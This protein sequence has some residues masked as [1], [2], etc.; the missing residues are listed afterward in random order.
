MTA[1]SANVIRTPQEW[2][3][4]LGGDVM[5]NGRTIRFPRPGGKS[6][7]RSCT[8]TVGS[9]FPD[10]VSVADGRDGPNRISW[11]DLKDYCFEQAGSPSFT[12]RRAHQGHRPAGRRHR[13][14]SGA[15]ASG[16]RREEGRGSPPTLFR[17]LDAEEALATKAPDLSWHVHEWIPGNNVFM[18]AGHGGE[19]KSILGLQLCHQTRCGMPFFGRAVRAGAAVFYS[20]EES[21]HELAYRLQ[22]IATSVVF[23]GVPENPLKLIS[24]ADR[25]ALLAIASGRLEELVHDLEAVLLVID[26]RADVF[27]GDEIDRAEVRSFIALLRG[28]AIR[29]QCAVVLLEHP[30]V[31]GMNEGRGF[32]GSTAWHNSV[33]GLAT[34]TTPKE[35]KG[36]EIDPCLRVLEFKKVQNAARGA[37]IFMR[38][39][40]GA[41]HG[42]KG[43]VSADEM[44]LEQ[45][46]KAMKILLELVQK[47]NDR[48][49]RL[50]DKPSPSYAAT[51]LE[52]E[53][54]A[55]GVTKKQLIWALREGL[56]QN[57]LRM[58]S[59][60]YDGKDRGRLVVNQ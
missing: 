59:E 27:G 4:I 53:A 19:G 12:D 36:Q 15:A 6:K 41:F 11:Q 49:Q 37:K 10:G 52:H 39:D 8:L 34:L 21:E 38:F 17:V 47:A 56:A 44:S 32:S 54:K 24:M 18:L 1:A 28:I 13:P 51:M 31:A 58:N 2:A 16:P 57:K 23:K 5:P 22:R 40:N 45:K 48:G 26:A 33:R 3:R 9:Q 25:S 55:L 46:A 60:K 20:A 35:E 14:G 7:D 29:N 30:S 50:S 43:G 42:D